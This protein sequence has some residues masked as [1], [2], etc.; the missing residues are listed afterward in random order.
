MAAI[1]METPDPGSKRLNSSRDASGRGWDH[2]A[3]PEDPAARARQQEAEPRRT[4]QAEATLAQTEQQIHD[5]ADEVRRDLKGS[6]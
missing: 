3:F 4:A 5:L 6:A 2:E 1:H